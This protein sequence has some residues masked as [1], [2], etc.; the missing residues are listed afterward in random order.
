VSAARASVRECRTAEQAELLA[1]LLVFQRQLRHCA[2][3]VLVDHGAILDVLC[4]GAKLAV[5]TGVMN[6]AGRLTLARCA[7]L[8]VDRVSPNES[9]EGETHATMYVS[10]LPPS[11]SW[12]SAR[13]RVSGAERASASG[14]CARTR[15]RKVS[16]E[17]R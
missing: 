14:H 1:Q 10:E 16:L 5:K 7:N 8:R 4:A 13:R 17:S 15:S 6:A 3:A 9:P 2:G 11:E 12:P